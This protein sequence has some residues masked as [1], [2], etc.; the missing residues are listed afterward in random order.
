MMSLLELFASVDD[1]SQVFLPFW[2][3]KLLADGSR[4]RL[5]SGQMRNGVDR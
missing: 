3:S 5:Q 2:E 4:K 1:F